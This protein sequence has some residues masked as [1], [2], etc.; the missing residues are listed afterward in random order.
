MQNEFTPSFLNEMREHANTENIA[1]LLERIAIALEAIAQTPHSSDITKKAISSV[2]RPEPSDACSDKL[3]LVEAKPIRDQHNPID[4][5][6]NAHQIN[7]KHVPPED[8]A[9]AVINSIGLFMGERYRAIE[10]TYKKIKRTMQMGGCITEPIAKET[11]ENISSICQ[12]CSRLHEIAFLEEYSYEKSPKYIIHA[13]TTT[14]PKALNF[15]SGQWLERYVV[16]KIKSCVAKVSTLLGIPLPS[17]HLI[18][19]QITLPNG[20]DFELDIMYEVCGVI[21]W[22]EAK[23]GAYQGYIRKYSDIAK[24]MNLDY[25]HSIM[26]LTD[27]T[28]SASA[29]LSSLFSMTVCAIEQFEPYFFAALLADMRALQAKQASIPLVAKDE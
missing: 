7:I 20:N 29:S 4:A 3:N 2:M 9:D 21:Y 10:H 6:L 15:L 8:A 11:Q 14:L 12:W 24:V 18:N 25:R 1:R 17:S 13:K 27:I 19:P 22:V 23:S 28:E 26:L 5:F 16:E